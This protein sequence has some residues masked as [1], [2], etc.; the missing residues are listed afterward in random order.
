MAIPTAWLL[1]LPEEIHWLDEHRVQQIFPV[2]LAFRIFANPSLLVLAPVDFFTVSS[3]TEK[4][5]NQKETDLFK[6]QI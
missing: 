3:S 4:L 5:D 6:S 1:V 2:R